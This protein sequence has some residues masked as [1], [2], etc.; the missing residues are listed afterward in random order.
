MKALLP[1]LI[2]LVTHHVV[3]Q[4][5]IVLDGIIEDL[6]RQPI[7]GATLLDQEGN[8]LS[9]SDQYGKFRIQMSP[10]RHIITITHIAYQPQTITHDFTEPQFIRINLTS[11]TLSLEE[12]IIR[13]NNPSE[14]LK[15]TIPGAT[16]LSIRNIE[17][18]PGIVD[19]SIKIKTKV[20]WM[21]LGLA[22]NEA[23]QKAREAGLVAVQSKCMKVEHEKL[24]T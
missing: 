23:A 6:Q 9:V 18:I 21:Q 10:G 13:D 15:S 22:H 12:V 24:T 4:N 17:A 11:N 5:K 16:S 19:E 3:A 7:E 2:L 14:N 20:V 8:L 1:L